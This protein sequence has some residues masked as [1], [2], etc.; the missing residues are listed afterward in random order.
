[1]DVFAWHEPIAQFFEAA[2]IMVIL[3]GAAAATLRFFLD[4]RATAF[5]PAYRAC[6]RNL[7]RA[8]LLGLEFLVAG[9]IINT[10][11]VDPTF[12]SVGVLA[13]IVAIRT[14]LSISLEVE[15]EGRWPWSPVAARDRAHE[16]SGSQVRA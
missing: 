4:L 13:I 16:R 14:F 7:G 6:R 12:E 8:I 15:I 2:G 10:V 9:D 3:L 11:A 1:M 5:D